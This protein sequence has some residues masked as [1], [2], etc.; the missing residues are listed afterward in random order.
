MPVLGILLACDEF[1]ATAP[2]PSGDA[3]PDAG[4]DAAIPSDSGAPDAPRARSWKAVFVSETAVN[5]R[6][7]PE[8]GPPGGL[9]GPAAADALCEREA[10]E[11]GLGGTYRAAVRV[12]A[13]LDAQARLGDV[14]KRHYVPGANGDQGPLVFE[15]D[16]SAQTLL[17]PINMT[18]RG[19]QVSDSVR[20]WTGGY[21]ISSAPDSCTARANLA[22]WTSAV[23][24]DLGVSGEAKSNMGLALVS[25]GSQSSCNSFNRVYC[26]EK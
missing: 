18:A 9:A 1:S 3:A 21:G 7:E 8:T 16:F 23:S 20:V 22:T 17:L 24:T 5:G 25:S 13:N 6:L 10:A 11:A 14:S 26:V 2:A 15:A 4:P 19:Q 12:D